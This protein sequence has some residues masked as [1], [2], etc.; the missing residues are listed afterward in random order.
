MKFSHFFHTPVDVWLKVQ[1][2]NDLIALHKAKKATS[3]IITKFYKW[4]EWPFFLWLPVIDS[5]TGCW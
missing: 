2:K 4:P 5:N 1:L 3:M